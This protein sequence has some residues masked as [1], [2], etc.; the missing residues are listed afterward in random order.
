MATFS[1][2]AGS[3]WVVPTEE[4][5]TL[6]G[7]ATTSVVASFHYGGR[8]AA[9]HGT[10]LYHSF[11]AGC[12]WELAYEGTESVRVIAPGYPWM[13]YGVGD[14][15]DTVITVT[16]VGVRV[17]DLPFHA[18]DIAAAQLSTP[19]ALTA[20][21]VVMRM[22]FDLDA[23]LWETVGPAPSAG[24]A[25]FLAVNTNSTPHEPTHMVVAM[26]EGPPYV[27]FDDG[28]TWSQADGILGDGVTVTTGR[29]HFA[30]ERYQAARLTNPME[31]WIYAARMHANGVEERVIARSTD[32]GRTFSDVVVDDGVDVQ[33][34]D[35]EFAPTPGATGSAAFTGD[36]CATGESRIYLYDAVDDV[37]TI[38][39]T[40]I[41]APFGVQS[42]TFHPQDVDYLYIGPRA[43]DTCGT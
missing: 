9:S 36:F 17:E 24:V 20:A 40:A 31:V 1:A 19:Y 25:K 13:V 37:L 43:V 8:M 28:A 30:Q 35:P 18:L 10:D 14:R 3:T 22:V 5:A 42:I 34:D 12:T 33:L 2:D 39:D 27:T 32:G 26:E 11:D 21:G 23:A 15:G 7:P 29:A 6:P 38:S 4:L 16:S 41:V